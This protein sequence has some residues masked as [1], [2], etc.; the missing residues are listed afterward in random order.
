MVASRAII[1]SVILVVISACSSTQIQQKIIS[2][3]NAS[4]CSSLIYQKEA[5]SIDYHSL[6]IQE[7]LSRELNCQNIAQEILA[8]RLKITGTSSAGPSSSD[9]GAPAQDYANQGVN[10]VTGK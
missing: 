6:L 7:G 2:K 10:W 5:I 8:F 4:L 1:T 3:S 9:Q